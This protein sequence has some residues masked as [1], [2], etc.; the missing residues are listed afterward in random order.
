MVSDNL[1]PNSTE[2]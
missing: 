1:L 2:I